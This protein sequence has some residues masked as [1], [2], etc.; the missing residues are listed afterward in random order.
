M[1]AM[2]PTSSK[3]PI[4]RGTGFRI[5]GGGD[6][7]SICH[8]LLWSQ[9]CHIFCFLYQCVCTTCSVHTIWINIPIQSCSL[10]YLFP[11]KLVVFQSRCN[12]QLSFIFYL[13]IKSRS[14]ECSHLLKLYLIKL[15]SILLPPL[16][17]SSKGLG[18]PIKRTHV[19][20]SAYTFDTRQRTC[21][22]F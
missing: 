12:Y 19:F 22:R 5:I 3:T 21:A 16:E 7:T 17:A 9:F 14:L 4:I 18:L 20:L 2:P 11:L 6:E 10:S 13:L 15:W 1:L 8:Q